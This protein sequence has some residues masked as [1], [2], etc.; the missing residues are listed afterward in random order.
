MSQLEQRR[1]S[2]FETIE[3]DGLGNYTLVIPGTLV[4]LKGWPKSLG[5]VLARHLIYDDE[6]VQVTVLWSRLP[7]RS[8]SFQSIV[9]QIVSVQPTLS[10][11]ACI[12]NIDHTHCSGS[13]SGSM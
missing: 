8:E 2:E 5:I 1:P 13:R 10:P 3:R 9:N 7:E 6:P 11:A 12:F 4:K